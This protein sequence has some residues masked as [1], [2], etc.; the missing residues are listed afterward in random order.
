M[1]LEDFHYTFQNSALQRILTVA[2]TF[3]YIS[4]ELLTVLEEST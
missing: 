1:L 2:V 4:C 3:N